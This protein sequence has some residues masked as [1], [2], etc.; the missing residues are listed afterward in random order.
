MA[1]RTKSSAADEVYR[2]I[3]VILETAR[4]NAYRAVNQVMVQAYWQI[5]RVIVEEEQKG[6]K[7]AGHGELRRVGFPQSK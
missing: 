1:T 5:G 2:S 6:R 4:D 7:R 3:A